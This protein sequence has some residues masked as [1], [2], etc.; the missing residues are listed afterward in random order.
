MNF[1]RVTSDVHRRRFGRN[2]GVG[3]CLAA[4]IALM[5]ALSVVKIRR[6]G[7][8]EG[9]DHVARPAFVGKGGR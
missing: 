9:F 6:T 3:L 2:L 7:A 8:V 1:Q 5:F 4:F